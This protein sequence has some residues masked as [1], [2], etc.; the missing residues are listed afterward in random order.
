MDPSASFLRRPTEAP[1][2][3]LKFIKVIGEGRFGTVWLCEDGR[4]GEQYACKKVLKESLKDSLLHQHFLRQEVA[5]LDS[6]AGKHPNIIELKYVFEDHEA[7][8]LMMEF[9]DVGDLFTYVTS[10]GCTIPEARNCSSSGSSGSG[11]GMSSAKSGGKASSD[12]SSSSSSSKHRSGL[13]WGL[14]EN[15]AVL[16]FRQVAQAVLFC[17]R[18]GVMH[19]DI[20]LENVLLCSPLNSAGPQYY[21]C[22][23]LP[24][25]PLPK[26]PAASDVRVLAKLADFGLA[27]RLAHGEKTVG[28]A[29]SRLYEAPEV[30]L[31]QEYDMKADVWSLGV[32]LFGMISCSMPFQGHGDRQLIR[33]ILR[34]NVDLSRGGWSAVSAEV[35]DLIRAML[36]VNPDERIS[37][38]QVVA[39]PWIKAASRRKPP[40]VTTSVTGVSGATG[41]AVPAISG[42]LTPKSPVHFMVSPPGSSSDLPSLD[43]CSKQ[44]DDK[45]GKVRLVTRGEGNEHSNG[46]FEKNIDHDSDVSSHKN[47]DGRHQKENSL[48]PLH[49][50]TPRG[51]AGGD[52]SL[53]P[54]VVPP[55][56]AGEG[57]EKHSGK[58]RS[59]MWDSFLP[60]LSPSR[61]KWRMGF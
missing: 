19:R 61:G 27:V 56:Q 22:S 57:G 26:Q 44:E 38:A 30:I 54:S 49:P 41:V 12:E 14:P 9:C 4:T 13:S 1:W 10:N 37:M 42:S 52:A 15:K 7:I 43:P 34:G 25:P 45:E 2:S 3:A 39:H 28:T 11:F 53:G 33:Q 8:Y 18:N 60:A 47:R 58:G 20:K 51:I 24:P 5:L 46:L 50:T 35:K 40:V 31:G 23:A 59:S 17:H 55:G 32:L 6:M 36:S 21:Y 16:V 29:G 48:P